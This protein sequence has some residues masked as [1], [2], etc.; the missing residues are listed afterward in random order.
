MTSANVKIVLEIG[1]WDEA[2][3]AELVYQLSSMVSNSK[4]TLKEL[5]INEM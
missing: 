2:K 1:N 5:T 3:S 4:G